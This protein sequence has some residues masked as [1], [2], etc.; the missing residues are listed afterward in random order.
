MKKFDS[1]KWITEN[2]YG[3][4]D[5][6]VLGS[7]TPIGMS[8]LDTDL[9]KTAADKGGGSGSPDAV[10]ATL[11]NAVTVGA[12]SPAQK[13]VIA[14]KALC[15]ALGFLRDGTPDLENM[16]AI[17]SSDMYIMDGHHRW[18]AR[19]LINPGASVNVAKI[20]MPANE[21]ITA[22]NVY[23]KAFVTQT[24]NSGVGAIS[25][26]KTDIPDLVDQ[27]MRE[28]TSNFKYHKGPWPLLSAEE[29]Q[30]SFGKVKNA[31]GDP[32]K[33]AELMK[34][35]ALKL[36]TEVHPD[37]PSRVD[38]PVIDAKKGDLA[39]VVAK[40]KAG[41]MD[42]RPDYSSAVQ[43]KIGGEKAP[44]KAPEKQA[45]QESKDPRSSLYERL[46]KHINKK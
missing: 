16:E 30:T 5:E 46:E 8:S 27:A 24:G 11:K 6:E 20:E 34:A 25:S 10:D 18:A 23:T 41:A 36:K 39:K 19:T 29:A 15:F 9:A 12:L 35:N 32:K 28:G 31:N 43:A 26:F 21:L 42:I 2:K 44:E 1:A 7:D 33:G 40:L 38:M 45:A 4:F 37:A 17:V 14:A 3:K 13:E 22:L